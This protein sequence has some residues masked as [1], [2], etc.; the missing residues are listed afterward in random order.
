MPAIFDAPAVLKSY[1]LPIDFKAAL[2]RVFRG[3]VQR[4]HS[5]TRVSTRH[6]SI[7]TQEYR[8]RAI[9]KSFEELRQNGYALQSPYSLKTKHVQF[10]VEYWVKDSQS[11]GSIENKL[12]YLRALASWIG[13][14]D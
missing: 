3:N 4:I 13:K 2:E 1:R 5:R 12:T 9:C 8:A 7:K 6:L 14:P 11:G 10:L